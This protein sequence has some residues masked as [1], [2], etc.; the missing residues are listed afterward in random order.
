V[1][2]PDT[3]KITPWD[4]AS[5]IENNKHVNLRPLWQRLNIRVQDEEQHLDFSEW[6][7]CAVASHDYDLDGEA[8]DETL[9]KISLFNAEAYSYLLFKH[10]PADDKWILLGHIDAWSKYRNSEFVVLVSN[11]QNW[12]VVSSQT[13]SG[14]GVASYKNTIFEVTRNRLQKVLDFPSETYQFTD[15]D[16]SIKTTTGRILDAK[17]EGNNTRVVIDFELEFSFFDDHS[18]HKEDL[19]LFRNHRIGEFIKLP[20]REARLD[21]SR[22]SL[23]QR[24]IDHIHNID[25]MTGDDFLKYN[26]PELLNLATY[27]TRTQKS[28]LKSYVRDFDNTAEKRQLLAALR[29]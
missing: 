25:S 2:F 6:Y 24:D 20:D 29:N 19:L 23:T 17:K 15:F 14:S 21:T 5:F 12:L 9:L 11:G 8:G 27:G 26:L 13:A 28:W 4:I 22:S 16:G 1:D 3:T 7:G 18:H 10:L